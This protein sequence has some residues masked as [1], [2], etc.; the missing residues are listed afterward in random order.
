Q[1]NVLV[2][3]GLPQYL[4][5]IAAM[6]G[7]EVGAKMVPISIE[8]RAVDRT[9]AAPAP[10]NVSPRN[11][12]LGKDPLLDGETAQRL[13]RVGC[14]HHTCAKLTDARRLLVD[15]SFD[16]TQNQRSRSRKAA[17]AGADDCNPRCA[18]HPSSRC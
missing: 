15:R 17:E 9:T 13:H 16:A 7:A 5:E 6:H 2:S 8:R 14:H 1:A 4:L 10:R 3:N 11:K 18:C 12:G